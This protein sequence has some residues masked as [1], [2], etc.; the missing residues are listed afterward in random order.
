MA[1]EA[2]P[3]VITP[4]Q[5]AAPKEAAKTEA[6]PQATTT[7]PAPVGADS[8]AQATPTPEQGKKVDVKV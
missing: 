3:T 7:A 5:T 1:I 6:K 4:V 2:T 8:V